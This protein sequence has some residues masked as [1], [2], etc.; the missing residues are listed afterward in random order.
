MV[1]LLII[2]IIVIIE[3]L[4]SQMMNIE[5]L[6]NALINDCINLMIHPCIGSFRIYMDIG[7]INFIFEI[8]LI[9]ITHFKVTIKPFDTS[10]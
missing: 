4:V 8:E 1:K 6:L 10:K 3:S 5:K 7:P 9:I 2:K